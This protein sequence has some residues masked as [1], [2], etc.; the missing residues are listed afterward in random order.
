MSVL[1]HERDAPTEQGPDAHAH[2]S[3]AQCDRVADR[4]SCRRPAGP[5]VGWLRITN[6]G[7]G[8]ALDV[9]V[10]LT[11]L[12]S[13]W[14]IPWTSH[15]IAQGESHDFIPHR[16]GTPISD[17]V[18]LTPLTDEFTHL[19]LTGSYRDALGARLQVNEQIE[20]QAWWRATKAAHHLVPPNHIKKTADEIEKIRREFEKLV[21]EATRMRQAT[22]PDDPWTTYARWQRRVNRVPERVRPIIVAVLRRLDRWSPN[23]Q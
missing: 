18:R 14:A 1:A 10:R 17:W 2:I 16:P 4:R 12:P 8:P 11:L 19:A 9:D 7:P 21:R 3:A 6:A 23:E 13:G 15:V 5:D 22:E 20:V